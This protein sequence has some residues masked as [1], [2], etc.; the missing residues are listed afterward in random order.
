MTLL[1]NMKFF[2]RGCAAKVQSFLFYGG[3]L[4]V[5]LE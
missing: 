1:F 4:V 3:Y 5:K 2:F